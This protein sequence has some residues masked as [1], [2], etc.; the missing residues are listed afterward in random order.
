MMRAI[1]MMRD[2]GKDRRS[3]LSLESDNLEQD[4]NALSDQTVIGGIPWQRLKHKLKDVS[5]DKKDL[6]RM[7]TEAEKATLE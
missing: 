5:F 6:L 4:W 1:E 3:S 7:L 2:Y